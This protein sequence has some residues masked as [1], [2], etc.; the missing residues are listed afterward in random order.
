MSVFV[1]AS[2]LIDHVCDHE[3]ALIP[4]LQTYVSP[5]WVR[6]TLA[7]EAPGDPLAGVEKANLAAYL[8]VLLAEAARLW[9]KLAPPID[10]SGANN[11][12]AAFIDGLG[13]ALRAELA[14]S[15]D[16]AGAAGSRDVEIIWGSPFSTALYLLALTPDASPGLNVRSLVPEVRRIGRLLSLIDDVVDL[17][18]DWRSSNA[19]RYLERA[20]IVRNSYRHEEVP[21]PTI[22][23][24]EVS[25]P[26]VREITALVE[27]WGQRDRQTLGAW[28]LYWLRGW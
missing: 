6:A 17:E 11:L 12:R 22:L 26:Y 13:E 1:V 14:S 23:A 16:G 5:A 28:I 18:D 25:E 9:R 19:N 2:A 20:G 27:S 21:W 24:D 3:Q 15:P 4:L 10:A 8:G 7:G